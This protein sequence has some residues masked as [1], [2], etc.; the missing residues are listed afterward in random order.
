MIGGLAV[1]VIGAAVVGLL[2][3]VFTEE[4][5]ALALVLS[6]VT[7]EVT[8]ID[9]ARVAGAAAPGR[10]LEPRDRLRTGERSRAVLEMGSETRIRLGPASAIEVRAVDEEGVE[11][12]LEGGAVQ[13][14]V[15]PDSGSVRLSSRGR[16]A[17]LTNAEVR[18]GVD[19]EGLLQLEALRGDVMLGGIRGAS[20]LEEDGRLFVADGGH[21]ELGEIPRELLL[22]VQWPDGARTGAEAVEVSGRTEPGATVRVTG[23][24]G[25]HEVRADASGAFLAE[26]TLH[27]GDNPV[28]VEAIDLLGNRVEVQEVV[29][30][31]SRGPTF[32]GGVE[33]GR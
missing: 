8:V 7:G 1:V 12:E 22:A 21:A 15:R 31:T 4:E 9:P 11:V 10:H 16:E 18:M 2:L 32:R 14:T 3:A 6:E 25:V 26:V 29:E 30:R 19:P 27:E 23:V 5:G 17:L 13:A 28:R 33:Y 20:L 24:G